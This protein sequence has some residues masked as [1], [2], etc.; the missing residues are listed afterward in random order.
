MLKYFLLCQYLFLLIS[1][2]EPG[3]SGR[4]G[5]RARA[6]AW[7]AITAGL[8][9]LTVDG[10]KEIV[11]DYLSYPVITSTDLTYR[12]ELGTALEIISIYQ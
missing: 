5:S 6:V 2:S 7:L 1:I 10:I 11:T 4:A 3:R 8:G 9:Y 12:A